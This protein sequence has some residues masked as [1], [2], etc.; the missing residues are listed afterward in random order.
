MR[1]VTARG[2]GV[3]AAAAV[4]PAAG[5]RFGYPDLALLDEE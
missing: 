4:L 3:L 2:Y 1:G 5:F